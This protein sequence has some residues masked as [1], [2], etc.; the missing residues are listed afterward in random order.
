MDFYESKFQG[1][2]GKFLKFYESKFHDFYGC[3]LWIF[4]IVNLR[5]FMVINF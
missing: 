1:F 2:Y 5:V 3:K 4:M